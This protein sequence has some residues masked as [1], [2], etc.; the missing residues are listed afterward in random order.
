[1]A[2]HEPHPVLIAAQG[3]HHGPVA[4]VSVHGLDRVADA[5]IAL[6]FVVVSAR[7]EPLQ[8]RN[9]GLVG[10]DRVRCDGFVVKRSRFKLLNPDADQI[11][12]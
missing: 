1:L 5:P 2:A 9:P 11:P 8:R 4:L 3:E 7:I 12:R 10:L 6:D